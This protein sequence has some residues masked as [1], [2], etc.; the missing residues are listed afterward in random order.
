[1]SLTRTQELLQQLVAIPSV[2]REEDRIATFVQS[3]IEGAG[4]ECRRIGNTVLAR[5]GQSGGPR[6]LLNTHLDTVPVG[7]GWTHDPFAAEW[8]GGKLYGRGSND[9]KA[10]VASMLVC[11]MQLAEAGTELPGE[12]WLALNER[13]ETDNFGMGRTLEHLGMPDAAVTG[14]PTSLEI[15]RAQSGLAVLIAE[16]TGRSCHAAHVAG[17][18]HDNALLKAAADIQQAGPFGLL[19]E[20]HALLGASTIAPTV[21]HSGERHN[22]VPDHAQAIFDARLAPP[23]SG[24][25]AMQWLVERMPSAELRL[26][27]DR[28]RAVETAES[29]PLV[30]T[31]LECAGKREAIG[32]ATLSDMALLP[33]IP[34]VKCGP[35]ATERS[36]T[37][38]E[39]V[40]ASEVEDGTRFYGALVPAALEALSA[41]GVTA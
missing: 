3:E 41:M 12:V 31:A 25:D 34:A 9:A 19:P 38:D 23:Y 35:G 24:A 10:S 22:V 28:L 30:K 1:V 13:E 16:W 8:S 17:V 4:L 18:E 15:V 39:F 37:P 5:Y 29:H 32:S 6:L 33:G 27:S 20:E 26:R 40:L 2:S 7:E 11:M 36:H 21:L 14:E